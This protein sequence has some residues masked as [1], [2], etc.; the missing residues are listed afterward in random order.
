M[1]DSTTVGALVTALLCTAGYSFRLLL[2]RL[3]LRS[4]LNK[5]RIKE[6]GRV[7]RIEALGE[8]G[9]LLEH[10]TAGE[11]VIVCQQG[12]RGGRQSG[13]HGARR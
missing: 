1:W 7:G 4:V 5:A 11:H 10:E 3:D 6:E 2:A 12:K 9:F 13:S 8:D